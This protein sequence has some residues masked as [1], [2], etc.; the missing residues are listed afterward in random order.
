[1]TITSNCPLK[2]YCPLS[3]K[4]SF[5]IWYLCFTSDICFYNNS[6]TWCNICSYDNSSVW[7]WDRFQVIWCLWFTAGSIPPHNN[8]IGV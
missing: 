1:M 5:C 4:N 7:C 6:I 8:S 3:Q 2:R